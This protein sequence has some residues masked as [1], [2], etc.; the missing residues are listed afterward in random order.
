MTRPYRLLVK[1]HV[2]KKTESELAE[3]RAKYA[4][5]VPEWIIDHLSE[6]MADE[7]LG[8]DE[9]VVAE[10]PKGSRRRMAE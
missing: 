5:G 3:L 2:G 6:K 8:V 10:L 9:D 7:V 1:K 4:E